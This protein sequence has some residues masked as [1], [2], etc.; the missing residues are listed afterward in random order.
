MNKFLGRE[1]ASTRHRL[2]AHTAR[3]LRLLMCGLLLTTAHATHAAGGHHAVDD[4]SILEPGQCQLETWADRT[5]DGTRS[6]V[7]LG[8]GC[9]LGPVELSLGL[10]RIRAAGTTTVASPQ[11]KW[12]VPVSD[13][14]SLGVAASA[15]LQDLAPRQPVRTLLLLATWQ[16]NDVLRLHANAGQDFRPQGLSG[17]H[18]GAAIEWQVA[19]RWSLVAERFREGGGDFWRTGARWTLNDAVDIDMSRASPWH[20]NSAAWWTVGVTWAFAR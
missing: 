5:T 17:A 18:A 6:S 20:G 15:S 9:R 11:V 7:H 12:A 4:A 2:M 3:A 8:P 14:V 10:D 19:P 13:N 16:P 1:A